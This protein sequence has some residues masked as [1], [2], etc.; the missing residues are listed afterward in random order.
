[1]N[2]QANLIFDD[3]WS[4]KK[5]FFSLFSFFFSVLH[6]IPRNSI[7]LAK[8]KTAKKKNQHNNVSKK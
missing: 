3:E 2:E 1:M 5:I 4:R 6:R 7:S 8:K